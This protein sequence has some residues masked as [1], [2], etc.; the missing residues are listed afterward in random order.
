MFPAPEDHL[1]MA[2]NVQNVRV[3]PG[4][5]RLDLELYLG[6]WRWVGSRVCI[7]FGSNNIFYDAYVV[8]GV[9]EMC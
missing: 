7:F 9:K 8:C 2:K 4:R 1:V 5:V 3:D 6:A